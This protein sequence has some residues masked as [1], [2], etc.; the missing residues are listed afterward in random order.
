MNSN[1]RTPRPRLPA[2]TGAP[3]EQ[4]W[5]LAD[6]FAAIDLAEPYRCE[7][8]DH[9]EVAQMRARTRRNEKEA[10]D[11]GLSHMRLPALGRDADT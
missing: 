4:C 2:V 11:A 7:A 1:P 6:G 9:A 3:A 10:I 8:E 5:R